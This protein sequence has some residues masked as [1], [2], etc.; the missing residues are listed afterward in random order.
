M[1]R[2]IKVNPQ[3][4]VAYIPKDLVDQGL[5]GDVD[6][7]AD[8][9]TLTLVKPGTPLGDVERSLKIVLKDIQFRREREEQEHG[10]ESDLKETSA[11]DK[12][13]QEHGN[14]GG[15]PEDPSSGR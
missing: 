10:G 13:S 7:Y 9:V 11:K 5:S 3:A 1:K 6:G 8:A 2:K 12:L 4:R 14:Q 15:S